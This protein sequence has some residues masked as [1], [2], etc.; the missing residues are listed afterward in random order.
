MRVS[1][2]Q[3]QRGSWSPPR[4]LRQRQRA[5]PGKPTAWHYCEQELSL[6]APLP[7]PARVFSAGH[8]LRLDRYGHLGCQDHSRHSSGTL[9]R[10]DRTG[11]HESN[12]L[13]GTATPFGAAY[14]DPPPTTASPRRWLRRLVP[15]R[16]A[17]THTTCIPPQSPA[18]IQWRASITALP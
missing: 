12:I 10:R 3:L 5:L 2:L 13:Q 11:A 7:E 9:P 14:A 16:R 4:C 17:A 15:S 6:F 8:I 1:L 18:S